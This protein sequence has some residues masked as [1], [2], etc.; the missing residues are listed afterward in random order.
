MISRLR[1]DRNQLLT[2]HASGEGL[3]E[4][5]RRRGVPRPPGISR[6]AW[7]KALHA[8]MGFRGTPNCVQFFLEGALWDWAIRLKVLLD[9]SRPH[10]LYSPGAEFNQGLAGRFVRI[11]GRGLFR[12]LSGQVV[13]KPP[14]NNEVLE[15]EPTGCPD[16]DAPNWA[17]LD[18]PVEVDA[19]FLAFMIREDQ[20]GP[21][22]QT[23]GDET[24]TLTVYLYPEVGV[25]GPVTVLFEEPIVDPEDLP[26]ESEDPD[27][28]PVEIDPQPEEI[29]P[30]ELTDG[31]AI[32]FED[33]DSPP[34]PEG[35]YPAIISSDIN[36]D[37]AEAA[38]NMLATGFKWRFR[39]FPQLVPTP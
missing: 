14:F 6:E 30:P 16:W 15:L 2:T 18:A 25:S 20:A 3:D 37:L 23:H 5:A 27:A 31:G 38:Q 32:V 39:P 12:V 34:P 11:Q 7:A 4:L 35:P 36:E 19:E 21:R 13:D 8:A 17:G 22:T 29:G 24:G 9:P 28:E 26:P 10:Q 33:D 1:D